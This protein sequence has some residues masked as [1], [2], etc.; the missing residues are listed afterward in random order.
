ML[1][2]DQIEELKL[3]C[4]EAKAAS[5]AGQDYVLLPGLKMPLGANPAVLDGLLCPQQHSGYTTRLFLSAQVAG[6]GNNWK[7]FRI[8]DRTWYSPS[9]QGIGNDLRFMEMVIGHLEVYR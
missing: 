4:P 1:A 7:S 6:K 2:Q 9:W 3:L 8:L 5:E